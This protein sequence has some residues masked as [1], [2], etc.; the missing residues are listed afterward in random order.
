MYSKYLKINSAKRNSGVSH[1][2]R[3]DLPTHLRGHSFKLCQVYIL[4]T[5]Y[6][7]N[8]NNNNFYYKFPNED[9]ASR[10][11]QIPVGNYD[12]LSFPSALKSALDESAEGTG[13]QFS[14]NL[15]LTLNK[16][17]IHC[18][19]EFQVMMGTNTFGSNK[20]VCGF[21]TDSFVDTTH[22]A[23]NILNMSPVMSFNI[24]IN[25]I[26]VI[27]QAGKDQYPTTFSIPVSEGFK[28]I[29]DVAET[30]SF[31]QVLQ[32]PHTTSNIR[33]SV[34]D[35]EYNLLDLNGGNW[36]MILE[37][38]NLDWTEQNMEWNFS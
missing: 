22:R 20:D 23:N 34:R 4:N 2:F 12:N 27:E 16:L 32:L 15:N 9:T 10:T 17:E 18:S 6:N 33:V 30:Q 24:S 7:V 5:F 38:N 29:I 11:A 28:N 35:E 36:Y 13:N 14:V 37:R 19:T 25:D 1:D 3:I 26:S 31:G 21:D 8:E